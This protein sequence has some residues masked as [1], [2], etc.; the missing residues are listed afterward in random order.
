MA[1]ISLSLESA[2]EARAL[3]RAVVASKFTWQPVDPEVLTS[4]FVARIAFDLLELIKAA[5]TEKWGEA[6]GGR[7]N[8]WAMLDSDR[9]EWGL[10]LHHCSTYIGS[11]WLTF[12]EEDKVET[13][14]VLFSPYKLS[15]DDF[16]NFCLQVDMAL[17]HAANSPTSTRDTEDS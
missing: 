7:W 16:V 9:A 14:R 8:T 2:D 11:R 1:N 4:R 17:A 12:S 15:K 6:V 13:A 5:D 10:A 3:L